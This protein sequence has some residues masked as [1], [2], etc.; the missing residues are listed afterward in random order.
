M[1]HGIELEREYHLLQQRLA[2]KV[3]GATASPTLLK[4]LHLLFSPAEAEL[5]GRLPNRFTSLDDLA[6]ELGIPADELNDQM[7][8]MARRGVVMDIEHKGQRYFSL[9]PVVIGLFEFTFMRLRPEMPMAE[10][11]QLFEEY[12]YGD[13]RFAQALFEGQ[14]QLFRSFVREEALPDASHTEIL[15]W[16]RAT[17][18]VTSAT[19]ISV[20]ICQC[21]HTALHLGRAC[22]KPREVCLT[23]NYAAEIMSRNGHARAIK[24]DEALRILGRCK[25]AG[26]A[27]TGDNVQ[28][29]VAYICNCCGCCCHLMRALKTF[30]CRQGIMTSNWIMTVDVD[31]CQGCG[32]C[33]KACPVSAIE[34]GERREG[35]KKIRWAVRKAELCLGCGVCATVCKSG[36]AVMRSRSQRIL[37]PATV[38]DKYVAMAIERGKLAEH[39]FDDP[40][41]LHYRAMGR[42]LA[43]LEKSSP[44]K[45]A[46]AVAPL[47]SVFLNAMVRQ[48]RKE[49]GEIADL[50]G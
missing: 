47:K 15:D 37:T 48:A 38:F 30:N 34:L 25:E 45:A 19:A 50:I 29:K 17:H 27:Q 33:V 44:F 23:F 10:L 42:I 40:E 43:G 12:F 8:A 2:K 7:T 16:E 35:D 49:A 11:A 26:L 9:P 14:T 36:A 31:R 13:N 1:G 5:A 4:I 22:D 32:K 6:A 24:R 18:V 3:E 41:K 39:I 21:H 46:M 20:G 28:Q